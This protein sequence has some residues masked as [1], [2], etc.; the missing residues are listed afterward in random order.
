MHN[1]L[2]TALRCAEAAEN[3]KALD[4][5]VLDLRTLT[6]IADYFVMCSG[7]SSTQVRAIAD[8]I[9]QVLAQAGIRPS[10]VEGA[11]EATWVLMDYSDVV[12]HIFDEQSRTYYSLEKLWGDAPRVPVPVR[13][14]TS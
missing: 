9:G 5:Q 14:S 13:A 12:V 6:T 3:K 11:P 1:S 8:E 4:V 7:T 2:D 10:H